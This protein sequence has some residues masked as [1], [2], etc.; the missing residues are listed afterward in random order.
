MDSPNLPTTQIGQTHRQRGGEGQVVG[1]RRPQH[2]QAIYGR[3]EIRKFLP[4]KATSMIKP[5]WEILFIF[6]GS[7]HRLCLSLSPSP[8]R[9]IS[10]F[11]SFTNTK[12]PV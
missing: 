2:L 3:C 5:A 7:V 12:S 11:D 9:F 8:F 6:H 4:F 10:L 1:R